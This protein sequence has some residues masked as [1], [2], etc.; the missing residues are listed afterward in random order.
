[1]LFYILAS[2]LITA[3][4]VAMWRQRRRLEAKYR[5]FDSVKHWQSKHPED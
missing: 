3:G 2:V 4:W 5:R 1:M